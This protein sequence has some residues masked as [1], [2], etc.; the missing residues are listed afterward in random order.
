MFLITAIL[1]YAHILAR[2]TAVNIMDDFSAY[3]LFT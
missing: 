2:A 1:V 3:V